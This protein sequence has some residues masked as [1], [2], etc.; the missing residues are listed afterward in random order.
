MKDLD[1]AKEIFSSG[2]YSFVL[3]KDDDII[4]E[5]ESGLA[6][7]VKLIESG[8]DFFEYSIC[9]KVCGR[10]ASFL[11]VLMGLKEVHA[12][13]M[14]K[15]SVQILDRAEINYSTDN[16]VEKI[17]NREKTDLDKFETAVIRSGSAVNALEDIKKVL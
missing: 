1:K 13:T 9:D 6:P 4:T 16:F 5:T 3:C 14:A 2:K 10:A 7:L 15:L 8:K 12:V 17:L 11:Y